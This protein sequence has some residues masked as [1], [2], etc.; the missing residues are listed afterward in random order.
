[1]KVKIAQEQEIYM[2]KA[3]GYGQ[4]QVSLQAQHE[5]QKLKD[6]IQQ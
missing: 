2:R 6:I 3:A 4:Q 5:I 1:M